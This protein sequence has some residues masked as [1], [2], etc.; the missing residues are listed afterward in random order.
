VTELVSGRSPVVSWMPAACSFSLMKVFQDAFWNV[1]T[2]TLT[3]QI[4]FCVFFKIIHSPGFS[5]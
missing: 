4:A 2:D 1:E 3:A 5:S